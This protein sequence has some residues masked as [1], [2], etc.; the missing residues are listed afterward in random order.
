MHIETG[1]ELSS[2]HNNSSH[3]GIRPP[4]APGSIQMLGTETLKCRQ[5]VRLSGSS[6]EGLDD[7]GDVD[8]H[9]TETAIDTW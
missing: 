3:L 7:D 5:R 6:Q 8:L 4:A 9:E 1:S 2:V